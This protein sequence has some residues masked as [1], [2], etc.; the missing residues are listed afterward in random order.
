MRW[1]KRGRADAHNERGRK[2]DAEGRT[3]EAIREYLRACELDPSWSVP[4]YNLGLVYKYAGDWERS[5]EWNQRAAALDPKDQ[6]GWWN[7]GIA[8]T[9]LGRW[10][11][12][13]RAWRGCGI[14]VPEG[15][16]PLDYRCGRTPIRLEPS[17]EAEVVWAQRL[18]PARAQLENVPL[19]EAGFRWRDVVLNDGAPVGYR[20][21]GEIEVSVFN[22]LALLQPSTYSTYIAL[23]DGAG[24]DA[25]EALV[26]LAAGRDLAAE[27]WTTSV[28]MLCRACSEGR[29]HD[30]HESAPPPKTGPH[31]VALAAGSRV[32]ADA[33]LADWLKEWPAVRV[34]SLEL[35]LKA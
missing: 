3:E 18:D 17:G 31:R 1:T 4:H 25:T 10:D 8:A 33:L 28:R 27:D 11:E 21:L 15:Q 6:A 30:H 14:D 2:L 13:R 23:V 26:Q 34:A 29:P 19:P 24:E 32:E 16:G 5:L 7:L 9:A 22:C 35:A 12:A 20:M